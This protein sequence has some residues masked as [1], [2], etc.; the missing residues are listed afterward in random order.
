MNNINFKYDINNNHNNLYIINNNYI[1]YNKELHKDTNSHFFIKNFFNLLIIN[2]K[3]NIIHTLIYDLLFN[4]SNIFRFN[5]NNISSYNINNIK[6]DNF[7]VK[8]DCIDYKKY[9]KN[10]NIFNNITYHKLK[11]IDSNNFSPN[12]YLDETFLLKFSNFNDMLKYYYNLNINY[13]K[14]YIYIKQYEEYLYNLNY[15]F[16]I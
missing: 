5:Y 16:T 11:L 9:Y 8:F 6:Y 10:N 2:K 4:K 7:Q 1:K 14:K 12:V 3:Y 15:I 13:K